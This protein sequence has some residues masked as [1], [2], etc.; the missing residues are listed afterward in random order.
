MSGTVLFFRALTAH[1]A[2]LGF[3]GRV[4]LRRGAP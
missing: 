4:S 2:A 1:L 3:E